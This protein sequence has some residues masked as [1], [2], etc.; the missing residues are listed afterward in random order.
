MCVS[1]PRYSAADNGFVRANR[2]GGMGNTLVGFQSNDALF[3]CC[4]T[5][6]QHL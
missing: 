4:R 3:L 1:I 6:R 2:D 5:L